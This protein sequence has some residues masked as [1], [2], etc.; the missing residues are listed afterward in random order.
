MFSGASLGT[1][2]WA[3]V[4]RVN[5]N[6]L[7]LFGTLENKNRCFDSDHMTCSKCLRFL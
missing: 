5:D 2:V 7:N 4:S 6:V 3:D 1:D